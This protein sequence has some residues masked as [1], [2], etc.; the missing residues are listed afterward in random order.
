[1]NKK[2]KKTL[3]KY[4]IITPAVIFLLFSFFYLIWLFNYKGLVYS[5]VSLGESKLSGKNYEEVKSLIIEKVSKIESDGVIFIDESGQTAKKEKYESLDTG[6]TY[7]FLAFFPEETAK[8]AFDSSENKNFFKFIYHLLK[9]KTSKNLEAKFEIEKTGLNYFL[10]NYFPSLIIPPENAYFSLD[11]GLDDKEILIIKQEKIG[12]TINYNQVLNDLEKNI[13]NLINNKIL[14]KT[15]SSYPSVSAND[16]VNLKDEAELILKSGES[17]ELS[18]FNFD[19]EEESWRVKADDI[20]SWLEIEDKKN[21]KEIS[22]NEERI[23]AYLE[24]KLVPK[25][26]KEI[27]LPKLEIESGKVSDWRV[28]ENGR[29]LDLEA[30]AKKIN[31]AF[32]LGEASLELEIKNISVES[33]VSENDFKIQEIIGTGHSSFKGSPVNR[34]HNIKVGADALHGLLIKPGEEFSLIK[35]LG[36]ID[37]ENGY[38]TELVIKDGKTIPEYGGGLCQV[39]T[40]LFRTT[41][42]SGLPITM[43][44]NHSYRVSYY[45]PAGTDATIYDPWPDYRFINDTGN[46]ILIQSRITGDDLYF[47]FWGLK[48]GR[49]VEVGAP[50]IYNIVKAPETKYIETD[51]LAPGEKKCTESS[52]NGASAY[53]DYKVT[54]PEGATTTPVVEKRFSSYYVPWQAVCLVGKAIEVEGSATSTDS[55][56]IPAEVQVEAPTEEVVENPSSF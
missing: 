52:H 29:E 53:F 36:E 19:N 44:R 27:I 14:V 33:F 35:A 16:L 40:T 22:L 24:E 45:E 23:Q 39:G 25:I 13:K 43:R 11:L 1:M 8:L 34:R 54:Y 42:Q 28:G 50:I 10:D 17:L 3:P 51:E 30:S 5:G 31:Q 18:Y 32:I 6:P 38:K 4:L 21:N 47:D 7:S 37:G 26:N 41:L 46:Y 56:E 9:P 2:T 20:V 48:D 55:I 12:K 15:I 49:E